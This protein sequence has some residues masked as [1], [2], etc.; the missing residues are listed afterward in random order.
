L[1]RRAVEFEMRMLDASRFQSAE[2]YE[3]YLK[4]PSG[5]L[6]SELGW[7]NVRRF[8]PPK[9]SKHRALDVG[10]GTGLASVQ[11]ARMGYEVVLLDS[12]EE[13]LRIAREQ[14]GAG[15][16]STRICFCHAQTG[17]LRERFAAESFDVVVCHNL[18]EYSEDPSTTVRDIAH[19][20]RKEGVLSVLVRNRAGEVL[21]NAI[22]SRDWKLAAA[23][24]TAETAVDSLYGERVGVFSLEEIRDLLAAAALQI[25]AEHGV[26]VFFDYLELENLTDAVY[27]QIFELESALGMRPDFVAIARYMQVIARRSGASSKE[28]TG[29]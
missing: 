19:V 9:A 29:A 13:M 1:F 22:K 17:E 27:S 26:R 16:V 28:V 20:L 12:S 23:N 2:K 10:G 24:L 6:R 5:R 7:E 3:A 4:T 11:L 18:L 21:K 15:G 25:V 14:A 8:L